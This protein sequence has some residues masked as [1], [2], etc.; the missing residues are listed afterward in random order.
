[1]TIENSLLKIWF[2]PNILQMVH[3]G[4]KRECSVD[5]HTEPNVVVLDSSLVEF[6]KSKLKSDD[7]TNSLVQVV[8]ENELLL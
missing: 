5:N 1:M 8:S 3:T 6:D 7:E 4:F 2:I